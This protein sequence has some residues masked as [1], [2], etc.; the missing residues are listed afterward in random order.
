M[1]QKQQVFS[2]QACWIHA[3]VV[4]HRQCAAVSCHNLLAKLQTHKLVD[5]QGLNNTSHLF[6][7]REGANQYILVL[8]KSSRHAWSDFYC[9]NL[10]LIGKITVFLLSY[11]DL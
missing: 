4:R 1:S 2:R 9:F 6:M 11:L 7:I 3:A 5:L 8:S 10:G